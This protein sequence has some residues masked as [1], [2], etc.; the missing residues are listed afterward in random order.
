MSS[1]T[2]QLT[3]VYEQTEA[4]VRAFL[5]HQDHRPL[6]PTGHDTKAREARNRHH[7]VRQS[8]VA[9]IAALADPTR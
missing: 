1:A 2:A 9:A 8:L 7:A 6:G 4:D 3:V 5:K